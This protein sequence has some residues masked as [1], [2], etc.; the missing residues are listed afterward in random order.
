MLAFY[1]LH[2]AVVGYSLEQHRLK[3]IRTKK[4]MIMTFSKIKDMKGAEGYV[5]EMWHGVART[6]EVT[7]NIL[8]K[9]D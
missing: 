1:L 6:F 5:N 9:H 4:E 3:N 8:E 2:I 7:S